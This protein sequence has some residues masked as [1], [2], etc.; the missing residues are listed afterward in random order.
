MCNVYDERPAACRRFTCRLYERHKRDG[1]PLASRLVLVRRA[2]EML[3]EL[4]S[5]SRRTE[6]PTELTKLLEEEFARA[7]HAGG[8]S[9]S[10]D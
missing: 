6:P 1:G 10:S 8:N 9:P 7:H 3:T 2:R 5:S 4:R